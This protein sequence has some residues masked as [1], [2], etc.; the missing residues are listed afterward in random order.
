MNDRDD[1]ILADRSGL[2]AEH[3]D[4]YN[5]RLLAVLTIDI[6]ICVLLLTNLN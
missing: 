6:A 3:K 5:L 4:T 2:K 1:C